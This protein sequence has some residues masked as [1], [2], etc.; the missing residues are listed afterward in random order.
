MVHPPKEILDPPLFGTNVGQLKLTYGWWPIDIS[1]PPLKNPGS[2]LKNV[3]L[4]LA[5]D[6]NTVKAGENSVE[7]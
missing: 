4:K 2:A 7:C 3:G 5:E 1:H 6:R